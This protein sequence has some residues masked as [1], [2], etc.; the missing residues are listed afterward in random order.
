MFSC[1]FFGCEAI[2]QHA[3]VDDKLGYN[4]LAQ[5]SDGN[6][7]YTESAYNGDDLEIP[8]IHRPKKSVI[9]TTLDTSLLFDV[10]VSDTTAP[11]ADFDV[12]QKFWNIQDYDGDS[13]I[14]YILE[15][16]N[17]KIYYNDFLQEVKILSLS[18]DTIVIKWAD[19]DKET[20]YVR[21]RF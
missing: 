11:V 17:L 8:N 15:D 19:F 18:K 1:C 21:W 4:E 9:K 14:P 7:I 20:Y 3:E 6:R 10:W 5:Q 2:E 13:Q 16:K 12:S